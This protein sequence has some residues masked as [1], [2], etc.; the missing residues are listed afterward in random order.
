M[1]FFVKIFLPLQ[2]LLDYTH[3]IDFL[4]PPRTKTLPGTHFLDGRFQ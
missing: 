3:A 2:R 1:I 4:G